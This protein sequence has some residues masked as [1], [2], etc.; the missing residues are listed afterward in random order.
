MNGAKISQIVFYD[1]VEDNKQLF[2]PPTTFINL[3]IDNDLQVSR[4]NGYFLN[5]ILH[6]RL[7]K[8]EDETLEKIQINGNVTVEGNVIIKSK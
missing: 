7:S 6:D 2:L 1:D 5:K 8:V 4:V 3:K